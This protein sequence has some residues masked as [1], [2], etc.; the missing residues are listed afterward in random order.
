MIVCAPDMTVEIAEKFG[1]EPCLIVSLSRDNL[2]EARKM[3]RIADIGLAAA[4]KSGDISLALYLALIRRVRAHWAIVP[5]R[6]ADF[7]VTLAQWFRYAPIISKYAAPIFVAQEFYKP[8]VL[9]A[10]VLDLMRMGLVDRVALPMRIHDVSCSKEPRLCAERA[11]RSLR[12]LC[13]V[14]K[15]VHLLGPALRSVRLLRN[16][17]KQCEKQDTVVSFDTMAYRR[18]PNSLIKKQLLGRWMPRSSEEATAM[19]E[20]WLR[21]ALL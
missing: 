19:L 13:G 8:R 12:T 18:A 2:P 11:E 16:A 9:E 6:F 1:V 21:Q 3:W 10:A 14:V 7:R 15:H 4:K 20:A 17:L 5:D